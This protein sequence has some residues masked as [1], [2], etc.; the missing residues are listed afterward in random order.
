MR[1]W[2]R[3]LCSLLFAVAACGGTTAA[4]SIA[5]PGAA[6]PTGPAPTVAWL[7]AG[8]GAG[9]GSFQATGLPAV[10]ADGTRVLTAEIGEDGARG[11]PNLTLVIRDRAD[12]V[13]DRRVVLA[14]GDDAPTSPPDL[15]AANAWIAA[16]HGAAAWAPLAA[17]PVVPDDES[18]FDATT[19]TATAGDLT[20]Q[21]TQVGRLRVTAGQATVV[22]RPVTAWQVAD[23]PMYPGAGP[24]EQCSNPLYL[25]GLH[26]DA[27]RHLAVA[28]ISYLGTDTCWEPDSEYHVVAW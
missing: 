5:N 25:S 19:W 26:V 7:A 10:S 28:R 13:V 1:P 3:P 18:L 21:L 27:D 9:D 14:A 22:D 12:A 8:D 2:S 6:Q 17:V 16:G 20:I 24:D 11:M 15:A 4:P 23:R